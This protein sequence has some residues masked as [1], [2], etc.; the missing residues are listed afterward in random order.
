MKITYELK[1]CESQ[2]DMKMPGD[3]YYF[4]TVYID[5]Q[6]I[7]TQYMYMKRK[8]IILKYEQD[9]PIWFVQCQLRNDCVE[10]TDTNPV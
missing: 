10:G 2:V 6:S 9:I 1:W 3:L 4:L 8:Y 7:H 5:K